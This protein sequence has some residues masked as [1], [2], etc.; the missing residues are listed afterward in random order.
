MEVGLEVG[1]EPGFVL[2]IF[3]ESVFSFAWSDDGVARA[4][5]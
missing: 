1:L 3:G 2:I 5:S 4:T